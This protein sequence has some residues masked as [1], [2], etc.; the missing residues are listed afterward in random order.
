MESIWIHYIIMRD[1]SCHPSCVAIMG[2][3]GTFL[4]EIYI[5]VRKITIYIVDGYIN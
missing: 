3:F 2:G 1:H 5:V 4:K